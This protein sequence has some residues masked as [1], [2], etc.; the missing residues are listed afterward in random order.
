MPASQFAPVPDSPRF[1]SRRSVIV[2]VEVST[3]ARVYL[4][5]IP[6][7]D[8][9]AELDERQGRAK[10]KDASREDFAVSRAE[11]IDIRRLFLLGRE[12]EA[13]D[14]CRKLIAEM[15]GVAIC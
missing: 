7:A 2:D 1:V 13:T 5:D 11:L 4:R 12:A 15:L 9:A 6:M 8:L 3:S 14:R 10:A